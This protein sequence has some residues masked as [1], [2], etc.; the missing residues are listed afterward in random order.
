MD[1]SQAESPP[2]K[3]CVKCGFLYGLTNAAAK[4][5]DRENAM[6]DP[7]LIRRQGYQATINSKPPPGRVS[8]LPY[9]V[10]VSGV[11]P[12]RVSWDCVDVL[13]CY[14]LEFEEI[15]AT[16]RSR[17]LMTAEWDEISQV[18]YKDRS[19]CLGYFPYHRGFTA[20]QHAE[21]SLED[22]RIERRES[23][24]RAIAQLQADHADKLTMVTHR[25]VIVTGILVAVTAIAGAPSV[26]ACVR[27]LLGSG[28]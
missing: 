1:N 6:F 24:E 5:A 13:C 17:P 12:Q 27:S 3:C 20:P 23:Q 9:S 28:G 19:G 18:I 2:E 26:I 15:S 25:L 8:S 22:R 10:Y 7:D 14:R 21:L 16:K 4:A 11:E